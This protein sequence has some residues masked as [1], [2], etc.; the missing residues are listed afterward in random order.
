M[1]NSLRSPNGMGW[2]RPAK[3]WVRNLLGPR[4]QLE[5]AL[6]YELTHGEPEISLIPALCRSDADFLD[7]GANV[8]VYSFFA[9]NYA[10]HVF[11]M[12]PNPALAEPLRAVLGSKGTVLVKGASDDARIAR[13]SIPVHEGQDV[14]TRASLQVDPDSTLQTR[15]FEISTM[16]ID[17]LRLDRLSMLKIDV[18]GHE[19]AAL[20]GAKRTLESC[21]PV[22]V[23]ECEERHNRGGVA[24]A[25]D[26]FSAL[27]YQPYFIHRG[28]LCEGGRFDLATFQSTASIKAMGGTRSADYINNFIFIPAENAAAIVSSLQLRLAKSA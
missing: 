8:G 15:E 17:D 14:D 27:N 3:R 7:V 1:V 26:F 23:V 13:F 25:F 22:A 12:E 18:E 2:L 20:R 28:S 9:M 6:R 10:R 21:R 19:L 24:L 11:A 16:P 5:R 4:F